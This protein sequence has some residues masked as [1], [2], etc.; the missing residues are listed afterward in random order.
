MEI[1]DSFDF[2]LK[3]LKDL[4]DSKK[5]KISA[6]ESCTGGLL[7]AILTS[8]PGSSTYFEGSVVTYSNYQKINLLKVSERILKEFGAVSKECALE[9]AQN[10]K[11][12]TGSDIAISITGIAGPDGGTPDKPVGTVFCTII[13]HDYVKTIKFNFS[14][15][16][17]IIR[18]QATRSVIEELLSILEKL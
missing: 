6:A 4:L 2:M 11:N 15:N 10:I 13:V 8:I 12:I 1:F 5:L 7:G 3:E 18:Y 14:G 17:N 9:M 16:R